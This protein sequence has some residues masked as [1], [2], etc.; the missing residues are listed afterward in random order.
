MP[1]LLLAVLVPG[2]LLGPR[3][4]KRAPGLRG[5]GRASAVLPTVGV[6]EGW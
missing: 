2:E 6:G 4:A 5:W 1:S 3:E